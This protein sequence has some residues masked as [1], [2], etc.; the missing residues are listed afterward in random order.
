MRSHFDAFFSG[1]AF[2]MA[3]VKFGEGK[4]E[5][6]MVD[7]ALCVLFVALAYENARKG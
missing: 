2:I 5:D 4:T 1:M 6:A 3:A 7:M